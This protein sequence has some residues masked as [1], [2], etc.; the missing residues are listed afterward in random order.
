MEKILTKGTDRLAQLDMAKCVFTVQTFYVFL[1]DSGQASLGSFLFWLE[2]S[3]LVNTPL[4]SH[5]GCTGL[6]TGVMKQLNARAKKDW[7]KIGPTVLKNLIQSM[8][9]TLK[10]VREMNGGH[11]KL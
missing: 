7:D 9:N 1:L 4:L 10:A 6:N 2:A 5:T 8:P 3:Q 11:T